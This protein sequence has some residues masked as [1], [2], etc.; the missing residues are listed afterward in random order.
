M[1][2]IGLH[3]HQP[4]L[5]GHPRLAVEGRNQWGARHAPGQEPS[6]G[7]VDRAQPPRGDMGSV[8]P[9]HIPAIGAPDQQVQAGR[10]A[11]VDC[12]AEPAQSP[13]VP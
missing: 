6:S 13:M 10:P 2:H 3:L 1:V 7:L 5:Q 12:L 9:H 11:Q 4:A 8:D